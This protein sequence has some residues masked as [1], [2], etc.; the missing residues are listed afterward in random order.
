ML[1]LGADLG[2]MPPELLETCDRLFMEIQPA[3]L[4]WDAGKK[5]Q[6]DARDIM[7]AQMIRDQLRSALP[8]AIDISG[9]EH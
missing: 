7:R 8:P 6:P 5:L 1:R 4:Q 2:I 3:H 9:N